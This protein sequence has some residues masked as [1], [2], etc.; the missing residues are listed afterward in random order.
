[1][2]ELE[3][4]ST[5]KYKKKIKNQTLLIIILIELNLLIFGLITVFVY[6]YAN[7]DLLKDWIKTNLKEFDDIN[8]LIR[9]TGSFIEKA[10]PILNSL[11]DII[12]QTFPPQ[13]PK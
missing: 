10:D 11:K 13:C 1:M 2:E 7:Q 6:V 3:I 12:C 8:R 5:P 4:L 9:V